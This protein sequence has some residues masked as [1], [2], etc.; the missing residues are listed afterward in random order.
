MN[1]F[2][3]GLQSYKFLLKFYIL[4]LIFGIISRVVFS[5]FY[6]DVFSVEIYKIFLYGIRMDTII[7]SAFTILLVWV[8]LLGF[9][10]I[11]KAMIAF[12]ASLYIVFEFISF[13]F[14]KQF[15][16]RPNFMFLEYFTHPKE[17][18]LT[19]FQTYPIGSVLIIPLFAG[20]FYI[21]FL[22]LKKISLYGNFL[23]KL[24][25]LPFILIVSF[26]GLRSSL[27]SSTPNPSFYSFS[28]NNIQNELANN[29]L[30]SLVYAAYANGKDKKLSLMES[31]EAFLISQKAMSEAFFDLNSLKRELKSKYP[32]QNV[33]LIIGESFGGEFSGFLNGKYS[34]PNLD[35]LIKNGFVFENLYGTGTRTHWGVS[36]VFTSMTPHPG[37]SYLKLPK[38]QKNFYTIA[39]SY[40]K[41]GYQNIFVYGGDSSFD[42]M[43]GFLYS[44][45]FDKI[46]D[47][48]D[49]ETKYEKST[50]GY[51]DEILYDKIFDIAKSQKGNF[52][53]SALTL[54]SHEPFDFPKDKVTPIEG[55]PINGF[56]N[57]IK[58]A[59]F[60]FSKF[61][62]KL[63][64]DKSL[65]NTVVAV[66]ADHGAGISGDAHT[67][68]KK[69][70]LMAVIF[71][72]NL[73]NIKYNKIA[74]QVDFGIT[75]L[76]ASGISDEINV[77]GQSVLGK[78][79][80][81][82]W[83][84]L[85]NESVFLENDKYLV[86]NKNDFKYKCYDYFAREIMGCE[87]SDKKARALLQSANELY[88]KANSETK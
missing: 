33:I 49:F 50:W 24:A 31:N 1:F 60:A 35:K 5:A 73:R 67:S 12:V 27:D 51:N 57:S 75:L 48:F 39:N 38:S 28:G 78:H 2:R 8:Y 26:L 64:Q 80:N 44:N 76:D 32:K 11:F 45:G 41:H 9:N 72:K 16:L 87:E 18:L 65:Q 82:A 77:S 56:A 63:Q 19:S 61:Y 52:F 71:S 7:F 58:Y 79:R 21:I 47:K 88:F 69:N 86:Y 4:F 43:S 23:Q 74:S 30:F 6:L 84:H 25:I 17:V 81:N 54:S 20:L 37:T 59:D 53:I 22:Q 3:S 42:N 13:Y 14:F 70:K 15:S 83:M 46:Y 55:E 68:I 29:S 10:K 40:K 34:T 36:S 66:I 85:A 62:E